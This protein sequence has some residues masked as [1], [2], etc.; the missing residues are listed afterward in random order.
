MKQES[1]KLPFPGDI[2]IPA[3]DTD[4][5]YKQLIEEFLKG[6]RL[7]YD[8]LDSL[9]LTRPSIRSLPTIHGLLSNCKIAVV[10]PPD[11]LEDLEVYYTTRIQTSRLFDP[12]CLLLT[13]DLNPAYAGLLLTMDPQQNRI[14]D[15]QRILTPTSYSG[16]G[17][18][19]KDVSISPTNYFDVSVS[20]E[21]DRALIAIIFWSCF[22]VNK[23]S[24]RIEGYNLFVKK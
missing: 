14:Y 11:L 23:Q 19:I 17:C 3:A 12:E 2:R 18:Q 9:I 16:N 24:E 20:S 4:P 15:L 13:P 1:L 6:Q 10:Y 21:E 7:Y 22:S 8:S 5:I